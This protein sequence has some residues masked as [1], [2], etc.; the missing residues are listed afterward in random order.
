MTEFWTKFIEIIAGY[1]PF[2]LGIIVGIFITNHVYSKII[3]LSEKEK[4]ALREEKS[5]LLEM[6]AAK[7]ERIDKLH[8]EIYP[9]N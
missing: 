3:N 2:P 6:L 4:E 7:E 5:A 1:G 8:S 9:Q